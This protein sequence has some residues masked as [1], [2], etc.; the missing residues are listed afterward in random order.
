[1]ILNKRKNIS[2]AQGL[3]AAGRCSHTQI[4][5]VF[6]MPSCYLPAA[7][8]AETVSTSA[9]GAASIATAPA[10]AGAIV[11]ADAIAIGVHNVT[12][13]SIAAATTT[14]ESR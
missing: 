5:S 6:T 7:S 8:T 10:P 12:A 1:M 11:I 9:L 13:A 3:H 2:S 14:Q 4:I